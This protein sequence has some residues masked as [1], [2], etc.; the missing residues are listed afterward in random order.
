MK[1][2]AVLEELCQRMRDRNSGERPEK[3]PP[4]RAETS[5][6]QFMSVKE[7]AAGIGRSTWWTRQYFRSLDDTLKQPSLDAKRGTREYITV[8][9][10]VDVFEREKAK[11]TKKK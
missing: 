9:I 7:A 1:S 8:T 6:D 4:G 11:F 2:Q 3:K 5:T 10:P